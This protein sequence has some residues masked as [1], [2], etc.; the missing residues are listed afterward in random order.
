[1]TEL[2]MWQM[3]IVMDM[4][5]RGLPAAPDGYDAPATLAIE[6]RNFL[7]EKSTTAEN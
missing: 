5:M 2:G 7:S 3:P 6:K 1:M 4:C